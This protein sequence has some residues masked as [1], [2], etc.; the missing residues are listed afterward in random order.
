MSEDSDSRPSTTTS[1]DLS[2]NLHSRQTSVNRVPRFSF[3]A[4]PSFARPEQATA[5]SPSGPNSAMVS[6][7]LQSR[8]SIDNPSLDSFPAPG[9][10]GWGLNPQ[11]QTTAGSSNQDMRPAPQNRT[12]ASTDLPITRQASSARRQSIVNQAMTKSKEPGTSHTDPAMPT[13]KVR[14]KSYFPATN[15][16]SA[17]YRPPR[18]SIGPGTFMSNA[19]ER[20]HLAPTHQQDPYPTEP[21]FEDTN[22][23]HESEER[24]MG[25]NFNARGQ[26]RQINWAMPDYGRSL[27]LDTDGPAMAKS[28]L[29]DSSTPPSDH[30][31]SIMPNS[32]HATG[33]A[34]RTIS[35]T[36]ARRWKRMST[37]PNVPPMAYTPPTPH[38]DASFTAPAAALASPSM[39]PRKSI[40]PSSS[41][42][43]PE[44][45][46]KSFSSGI[47]NSS[48]TSYSSIINQSSQPRLPQSMST[49]RLP[50]LKTRHDIPAHN[51]EEVVPPVPAIPKAYESPKADIEQPFFSNFSQR[52]SSLPYEVDESTN[53]PIAPEHEPFNLNTQTPKANR[54]ARRKPALAAEHYPGTER[55]VNGI[56]NIN[57]RTLQQVQLP[58]LKLLPLSAPTAAKIAALYSG[59]SA[60]DLG[61]TTPQPR[62]GPTATPSTP[63]T[64]SKASFSRS[65][66]GD[67]EMPRLHQERSN[68]SH[69]TLRPVSSSHNIMSGPTSHAGSPR[70]QVHRK[71]S[72]PFDT[73]SLPRSSV[74]SGHPRLVMNEAGKSSSTTAT[75]KSRLTGPRSQKATEDFGSEGGPFTSP[76]TPTSSFSSSIRRK[77]SLTGR[78]SSK[79]QSR[80]ENHTGDESMSQRAL[81]ELMPPPKLPAS[82]TWH[83]P[84][85]SSPT[86]SLKS[87][88]ARSGR[89]V[90][91]SSLKSNHERSRSNTWNAEEAKR[92][93]SSHAPSATPTT[94]KAIRVALGGQ[95]GITRSSTDV[96]ESFAILRAMDRDDNTAEEEMRKLASKRKD[97]ERAARE[98]DT[99]RR[100]A[101]AKSRV[102]PSQALQVAQLN[103]F[104]KGEII[105]FKDVYFCGINGAKKHQG[106][107]QAE[108]TNFGYDDDRGDYNIVEGDHLA[109][110]YEII[111][112]LGKGSFGQ[113]AR[114]IDHKTGGLVAIKVIRNK[115]R[116]HQQALIE[117]DILQKL[118]QWVSSNTDTLT[119]RRRC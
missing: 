62:S 55:R 90:S 96:R 25:E 87:G 98:L 103:I 114:C 100:R 28:A 93:F 43:T 82:T 15:V 46:R 7:E 83:G 48:S 27:T 2:S 17:A 99:L 50:T 49:S 84:T 32:V 112:I 110:R 69:Q 115:K 68:S 51:D 1:A 92:G 63:M 34:A 88:Q 107:L 72:L 22:I 53:S 60:M 118:R 57:R 67:D 95:S 16:H 41:R 19:E 45:N 65:F 37:M 113:V 61:T 21:N 79:A 97:T 81:H 70:E 44:H 9:N 66:Q 101:N 56:D 74:E 102:S 3:A 12:F 29:K 111:D 18:K 108:T 52:K 47:S 71:I 119:E 116:F 75:T 104:E 4:I 106:D 64:A 10:G 23:I 5:E 80:N 14:R 13:A 73:A 85:T 40:T 11:S 42:T 59:E 24:S 117:V 26:S 94:K 77:L 38:S 89:K 6:S 86:P 109:Y 39:L 58:P 31:L 105:D 30:R 33:L 8:M 91:N 36:D 76:A 20:W 35:P 54:E 78:R